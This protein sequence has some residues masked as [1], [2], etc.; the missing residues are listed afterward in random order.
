VND[1]PDEPQE[2]WP[3]IAPGQWLNIAYG[4]QN[5]MDRG[6]RC[7]QGS[8]IPVGRK[9]LYE[10]QLFYSAHPEWFRGPVQRKIQQGKP[11]SRVN[12]ETW[13]AA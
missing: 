3:I 11:I 1:F 2:E 6:L 7:G 8:R 9:L 4:L 5:E 10:W 13:K 12:G